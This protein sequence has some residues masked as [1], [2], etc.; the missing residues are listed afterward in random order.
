MF[1]KVILRGKKEVIMS[2][3]Q[4]STFE[5]EM[6]STSFRQKFEKKYK[7]FLLSEM[8]HTLIESATKPDKKLTKE[9]HS[10]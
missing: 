9:T 3:K 8:L 7:A 2:K 10:S 6:K 5:R 1:E 4:P